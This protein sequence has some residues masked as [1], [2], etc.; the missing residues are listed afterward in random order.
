MKYNPTQSAIAH[1][2]FRIARLHLGSAALL[3]PCPVVRAAAHHSVIKAIRRF[4]AKCF[5][6]S[7]VRIRHLAFRDALDTGQWKTVRLKIVQAGEPVLRAQAGQLTYEEI[8]S[9]EMQ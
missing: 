2:P 3:P 8:L 5:V 9:D 6:G 4:G 7:K 1:N